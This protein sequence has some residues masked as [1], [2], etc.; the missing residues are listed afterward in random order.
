MSPPFPPRSLASDMARGL[1]HLRAYGFGHNDMKPENV[2][3]FRDARGGDLVAKIAD[4]GCALG[5][6][7]MRACCALSPRHLCYFLL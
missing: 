2:L 7:P 4:L 3:L 5:A 6:Y 1:D